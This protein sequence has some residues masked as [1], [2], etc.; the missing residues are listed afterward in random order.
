MNFG[1]I[2]F[3]AL[4]KGKQA[5]E[6][7]KRNHPRFPEFLKYVNQR[8]VPEGSRVTICIEYPNGQKVSS[9][10]KMKPED[11]AAIRTLQDSFKNFM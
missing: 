10:V 2:D 7:F 8:G 5:W 3:S 9:D 6:S 1:N 11:A 4:N